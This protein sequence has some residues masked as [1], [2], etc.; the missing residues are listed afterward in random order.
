MKGS[1]EIAFTIVSLTV[2]LIA[3]LIPLLF[4]QEVVGRLFREFAV[5]LAV[6]ILISAVV[7]LTLVPMLCAKLL[8][9]HAEEEKRESRIQR[10][11]EGYYHGLVAEYDRLLIWVLKHQKLTLLVAIGTLVLTVV[12]YIAIPKGFFPVQ[13]TGFIQAITEAGPTVSFEAMAQR[14]QQLAAKLLQDPDVASLSSFIG[15]DGTNNTLNSG[16]F[17]INLKP[18]S[19]RDGVTTVMDRLAEDAHSVPGITFYLQ[20]VQDLTTDSVVSRA[21]YQFVLQAATSASLNQYVPKLLAE[22]RRT[23][24]IRNVSTSFLDQGLSAHVNVDRDTAARFGVTAATIDNALYD[25]FGQRMISNIFT[26]P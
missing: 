10:T 21:Q 4:M 11:V 3:V 14:Q 16:R 7:S 8:R 22:L 6:T 2:S 18:K 15:V 5:T 12:M 20:P 23:R 26:Q 25:S 19:Q 9:S 13:D 17:L 24:A 1:G